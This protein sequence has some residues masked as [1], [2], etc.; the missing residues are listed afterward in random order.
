MFSWRVCRG[1]LKGYDFLK[2]CYFGSGVSAVKCTGGCQRKRADF[3]MVKKFL[4]ENG[5][6]L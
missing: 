5:Y 4:E 2:C 3:E 1:Y 6:E